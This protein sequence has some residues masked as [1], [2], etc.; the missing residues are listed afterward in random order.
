MLPKLPGRWGRAEWDTL[1]RRAAALCSRCRPALRPCLAA[2]GGLL[3]VLLIHREVFSFLTQRPSY[4]VAPLRASVG[5]RWAEPQGLDAVGLDLGGKSLFDPEVVRRV[6]RAFEASPWVKRVAAVERVFPDQ[7]RVRV[8]YRRPYVAVRRADGYVLL[9]VD[10]VRLPGVYGEPP[11]CE[12]APV[13]TGVAS[14]P[15]APGRAWLDPALRA[16][17]ELADF[18]HGE[19]LL[20]RLGVRE[21]DVSNFGGRLDPRRT[22]IALVAGSGCALHWGR[23]PSS[24][25]FGELPVEEKLEN[26]RH[27][28]GAYPG[29]RG[30]RYAKLYFKGSR[31]IEVQP[32]DAHVQRPR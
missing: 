3:I 15:P 22:E 24:A 17:V 31:A 11:A 9:D 18:V 14:L 30:L 23:A 28:L 6:G 13:V 26:L 1:A 25:G 12:R 16:G 4:S 8:E 32:Q 20:R 10:G 2:L 29:L 21:V 5:P 27:V 7:V 19:S